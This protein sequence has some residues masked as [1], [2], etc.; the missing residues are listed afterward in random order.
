ML[1]EDLNL[2]RGGAWVLNYYSIFI[3]RRLLLGLV[4]VFGAPMP[5]L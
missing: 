4:L 5:V 2:K 1:Y 3:F